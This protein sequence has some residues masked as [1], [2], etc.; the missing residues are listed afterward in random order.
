MQSQ[1]LFV[2]GSPRSGTTFLCNVLNQHPLI[3]LTNESRVFVLL[4]H[5]LEIQTR[6]P[7]LLEPSFRPPF[8]RFVR[9]NAGLWVEQFYREEL[10][11]R[12]PIWGDKHPPYADPEVMS[13]HAA[14]LDPRPHTGSCLRTVQA[15]LPQAKF[16]HLH[17][18]PRH[19]AYS[20][21]C[22]GWVA[23]LDQGVSVWRR[24]IEEIE[25]FFGE[26]R[27]DRH[28]TLCHADLVDRPEAATAAITA[29]LDLPGD[30]GIAD[31]L[32][33]EQRRPTPFSDPVSDLGVARA[34]ALSAHPGEQALRLAGDHAV[35][36]GYM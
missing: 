4:E 35:R 21:F 23:S 9:R 11:I 13:A 19:V 2:I 8:T 5:L 16:I 30:G 20:M 27:P 15:A 6:I 33:S 28:L 31:F 1:P 36:L 34:S 7:D 18:D 14:G 26:I 10:G 12:A 32:A 29:F 25:Q 22:K 17:R 3:H 24:Y